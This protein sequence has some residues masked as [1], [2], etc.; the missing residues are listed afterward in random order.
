MKTI[1][2]RAVLACSLSFV[3]AAQAADATLDAAAKEPGAVVSASGLVYR[4]LKDGVGASPKASD[5]VKVN[6]R[7]TFPD[8]K[9][10]DSSYKRNQA[11]EFPLGNVIKCWT[12]GVQR[13]KVGG[14]AKLTCPSAIAYG[15]RGAG[16]VIPPNAT[17]LFE[18]E[19]LAI[20]G[21]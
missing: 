14:K 10:F 21:Q 3:S 2:F 13:M 6:Y 11:I 17:L 9:E 1:F 8:G 4:S 15:E 16:G 5:T 7:G 20:K 18:V 19:L 12:E